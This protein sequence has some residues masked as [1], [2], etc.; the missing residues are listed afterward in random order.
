MTKHLSEDEFSVL[1]DSIAAGRSSLS[2]SRSVAR[3]F[4]TH[5]KHNEAQDLMKLSLLRQKCILY[6]MLLGSFILIPGCLVSII[7]NFG[8]AAFLALPLVCIFWTILA[9]V[10]T[11]TGTVTSS[12]ILYLVALAITLVTGDD[13]ILP[14][15]LFASSLYLFRIAHILAEFFL[16]KIVM[17]SFPTYT[18]LVEHISISK[19]A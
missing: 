1:V 12:T 17:R 15:A 2:I 3:Q 11:E 5:V 18:M 19:R 10:T 7:A 14:I 8:W 16:V 6:P 9:G 13:Y 4:F